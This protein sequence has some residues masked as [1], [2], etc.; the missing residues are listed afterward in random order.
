M[1]V[2]DL[3]TLAG[4]TVRTVRYYHQLGLLA[5]PDTGG[6]WRSY[7]FAHLTRLMRIRWLVASGVPLSEVARLLRPAASGDERAAVLTDLDAVQAAI[8]DKIA[9]LTSQ[10][11]QV[12][13][14]RQRVAV[15]GRLS[16]LPPPVERLYEAMLARNLPAELSE[17]VRRERDL[18]ELLCYHTAL[19]PDLLSIVA[20]LSEGDLDEICQLWRDVHQI[21]AALRLSPEQAREV[22]RLVARTMALAERVEPAAT[23]RLLARVAELDR[24]AVR[25]VVELAYPAPAYRDFVTGFIRSAQQQRGAA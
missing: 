12:E 9:T 22:Q 13:L 18:L 14:L 20:A 5:V 7:G 21:S 4:T 15:D 6:T 16:P 25:A 11:A 3:A 19:P 24:P 2:K 17:A 10:R 23:G 8:D 1:R